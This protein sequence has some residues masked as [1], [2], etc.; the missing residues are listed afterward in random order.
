MRIFC[1]E[2]RSKTRAGLSWG[3]L[4]GAVSTAILMAACGSA[5]S[6]QASLDNAPD[7]GGVTVALAATD[8]GV[9]GSFTTNLDSG[10]S[11]TV[12]TTALAFVPAQA[13]V[14]V[15]GTTPQTTTF[16]LQATLENGLTTMV[17]PT[18]MEFDRP[19]LASATLGSPMSVTASGTYGGTGHLHAIFGGR[20]AVATLNVV[21]AQRSLGTVGGAIATALDGAGIVPSDPAVTSILYPYDKTVFPLGLTAPIVMWSAP[22]GGTH[23]DDVYRLHLQESAYSYDVYST[24]PSL[25]TSPSPGD[26]QWAIDQSVWDRVTA[27]NAGPSDPLE[28]VLSRYDAATT[29]AAASVAISWTVAPASLRG[30]IYYWTASKLTESDGGVAQV[31]HI[32]RMAPGSG[33]QPA[34]MKRRQT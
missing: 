26:A 15:D 28:V 1:I 18:S 8:G 7:S 20:E 29:T 11:S 13:T 4:A 3:F 33:A 25:A 31:G 34:K 27:S 24:T 10:S 9:T 17:T 2:A 6:S 23:A 32:T 30:A 21:V 19:D 16:Q 12:L 14:T 5:P 22:T